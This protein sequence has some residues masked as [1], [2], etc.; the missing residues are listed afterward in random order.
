MISTQPDSI[1]QT[2]LEILHGASELFMKYGVKSITMDEIARHL[3][4]SK[5]TIYQHFADK[6]EL[7]I[8]FTKFV[9]QQ[10]QNE[11]TVLENKQ[12][13][14]MEGLYDLTEFMRT[15][16]C[17]INPSLLFDLKKYFPA[18]WKI[19]VD[20][21]RNFLKNHIKNFLIKGVNEGYFRT[22]ID[23]EII[24]RMRIEQVEM[25]FNQDIYPLDEFNISDIHMQLFEHFV[26]GICTAKGHEKLDTLYNK[27]KSTIQ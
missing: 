1:D 26:Y 4:M 18:A 23:I 12:L 3:S 9:L 2:A 20:H 5:K 6:D 21:K 17:S 25:S 22:T 15:K 24:C 16:V 7:V 8:T 13:D 10:Q 19:F 27:A 11:I 14:V